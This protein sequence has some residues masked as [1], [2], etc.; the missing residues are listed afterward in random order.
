MSAP[1][2]WRGLGQMHERLNLRLGNLED[3]MIS[4]CGQGGAFR[5]FSEGSPV[6]WAVSG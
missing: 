6:G 5:N 2:A 4:G 3:G 1:D